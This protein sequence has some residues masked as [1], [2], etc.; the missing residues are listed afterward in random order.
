MACGHT[1]LSC[2]G[3]LA[4]ALNH[5]V[6]INLIHRVWA[7]AM[8]VLAL[9]VAFR[10]RHDRAGVA[11]IE[12]AALVV[13]VLYFAQAGVGVAVLGLGE[14]TTVEVLHSSIGSLTWVALATLLSLTRTLAARQPTSASATA[15]KV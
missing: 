11:P 1:F 7:G 13:S 14:N 5:Q 15:I 12:R 2:N 9:W 6:I 10:S 4:P 3:S 8:L